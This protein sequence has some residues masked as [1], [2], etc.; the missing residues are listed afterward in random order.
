L[1]EEARRYIAVS[2]GPGGGSHVIATSGP[3]EWFSVSAWLYGDTLVLQSLMLALTAGGGERLLSQVI[4]KG[5][6]K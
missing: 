4:A 1:P 2:E 5:E 3:R 6:K